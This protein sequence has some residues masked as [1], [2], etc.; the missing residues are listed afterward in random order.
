MVGSSNGRWI[1][2]LH[3]LKSIE[4]R[5]KKPAR[6]TKISTAHLS[7]TS[8]SHSILNLKAPEE[9]RLC[10]HTVLSEHCKD[11][12]V[13]RLAFVEV[14]YNKFNS[15]GVVIDSTPLVLGC[16]LSS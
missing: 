16:P 9:S 7:F 10:G 6:D 4:K 2:M 8:P 15:V 14:E 13:I 1:G 11:L 3:Q 5:A 12:F